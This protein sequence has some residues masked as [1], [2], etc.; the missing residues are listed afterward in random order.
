MKLFAKTT[1]TEED[2]IEWTRLKIVQEAVDRAYQDALEV[3]GKNMEGF[4]EGRK[5][6]G[7]ILSNGL[8]GIRN[9]DKRSTIRKEVEKHYRSLLN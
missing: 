2:C 3:Y 5:M 9:F 4:K 8:S 1:T 7:Y 6:A